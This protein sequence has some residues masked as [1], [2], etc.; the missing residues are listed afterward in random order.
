MPKD[1][2][3]YLATAE[4]FAQWRADNPEPTASRGEVLESIA[5]DDF[6]EER[7]RELRVK[8][9]KKKGRGYNAKEIP[10]VLPK[11]EKKKVSEE[12]EE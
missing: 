12:G 9:W 3:E 2:S 11:G 5:A 1:I 4:G 8:E 10:P 7:Q 6:V